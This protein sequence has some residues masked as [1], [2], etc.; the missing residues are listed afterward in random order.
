MQNYISEMNENTDISI[1]E[2]TFSGSKGC[3]VCQHILEG[4]AVL[5]FVHE[6]DVTLQF[7]CGAEGHS[8]D[9]RRWVHLSHVLSLQPD[10]RLLPKVHFGHEAE[11]VDQKSNWQVVKSPDW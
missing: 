8:K 1:A 3:Y 7:L 2:Y 4:A 10:L 6:D 5:L 9:D 11:R